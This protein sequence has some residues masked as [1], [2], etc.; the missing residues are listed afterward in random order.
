MKISLGKIPSTK[1]LAAHTHI[2]TVATN[3]HLG[4]FAASL[5]KILGGLITTTLKHNPRFTGAADQVLVV[6]P[7]K[8][9]KATRILLLGI[10]DVNEITD[11]GAYTIGGAAYR[12]VNG[13]GEKKVTLVVDTLKKGT[14][15]GAI[16]A[17]IAAGVML[18][19]Y[20]FLH[21][22]TTLKAA[23]KPS[24]TE[25]VIATAELAEAKKEFIRHHAIVEGTN[26]ARSMGNE[27]PNV[28]HPIRAAQAAAGLKKLGIK[29]T[30]FN[31]TQIKKIG[32]ESLLA[33]AKGSAQAPRVVVMEYNGLRN[34]KQPP[35]ALVG[36]GVTF[37]SG[38]LNIKPF[39]N[40]WDMKFDMQGASAVIG[41]LHALA[42]RKAKIRVVGIVGFVENL[43]DGK[44]YRP[45]DI[46]N[47]L[48]GQTIE[49]QN[50]DAE[51][52]LI[53]N[54][55]LWYAQEKYKPS[56]LINL[57]TLTGACVAALGFEHAGLFSNNEKLA[58]QLIEAG[59]VSSDRLWRLPLDKNY[60]RQLNSDYADMRNI[61]NTG[62]AGA[63]TAAQFLQRF[64]KKGQAW[65]HLDIAGTAW[66]NVAHPLG[67]KGATGFGVRLLDEL[68][69]SNFEAR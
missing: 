17:G 57:A 38:G 58:K 47:S 18:K 30:I 67:P 48:S 63:T 4:N 8:S 9:F 35:L 49:V 16:A 19:S 20:A 41:T 21:Y 62:E 68:I 53:L 45:G 56:N 52:R 34:S 36:K 6:T 12:A 10:G 11:N 40:M 25:A 3:A 32:M 42:K 33:V 37:D 39:P 27:P 7:P 31:E 24:H 50:T 59:L 61:G 23:D 26:L 28:M 14:L 29:V 1:E 44:N 46:L 5:D 60:D 55:L 15:P 69:Y 13:N 43:L 22:R 65:A 51:G 64:V 2:I 54:D 66:T